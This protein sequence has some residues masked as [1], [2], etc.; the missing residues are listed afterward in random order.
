MRRGIGVYIAVT[1]TLLLAMLMSCSTVEYGYVDDGG[2]SDNPSISEVGFSFDW[3]EMSDTDKPDD[4]TVVMSRIV[5]TVHYVYTLDETGNI[6]FTA[7]STMVSDAPLTSA[8]PT[9]TPS[10]T[11]TILN[12]D[13]YIMALARDTT[14]YRYSVAGMEHFVDSLN[15]SMKDLYASIPELPEDSLVNAGIVDFNPI[16][17]II[18]SAEPLC[19]EVKKQSIYPQK[20]ANQVVLT[21]QSLVHRVTFKINVRTVGKK[22]EDGTLKLVEIDSETGLRGMISGVPSR[23]QLMSGV[24][25]RDSTSKVLFNL[26]GEKKPSISETESEYTFTGHVDVLGLFPALKPGSIT[27][28]GILQIVLQA[29]VRGRTRVFFASINLKD[30]IEKADMMLQTEDHLGYRCVQGATLELA[31][32]LV[33]SEDQ[34]WSSGGNG[35]EMWFDN[36]QRIETEI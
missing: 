25:T 4:L 34:I 26:K 12:G 31:D 33:V 18:H 23:I 14:R 36:E 15:I 2:N 28:P 7:D 27:G 20:E 6:L 1:V 10:A 32:T 17:P 19:L 29:Q 9:T 3:G 8:T 24:V 16:Y 11:D 21:P 13:Y 35:L 5:N 30:T 22:E